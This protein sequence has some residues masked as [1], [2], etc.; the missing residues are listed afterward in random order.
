MYEPLSWG[1]L[2]DLGRCTE[3]ISCVL[4][5]IELMTKQ[6][7]WFYLKKGCGLLGV[8]PLF[9]AVKKIWKAYETA[10]GR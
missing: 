8:H 2:F 4:G 3:Q 7:F 9:S 6:R 5:Q 10:D 1:L